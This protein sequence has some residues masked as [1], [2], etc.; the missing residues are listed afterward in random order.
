MTESL[1]D[2]IFGR[3]RN[4]LVNSP[5]QH[6]LSILTTLLALLP[7]SVFFAIYYLITSEG[8]QRIVDASPSLE[9]LVRG[10]DR[11]ES[12]LILS[13]VLF[14]GLGVYL[15]AL[16]ET[17]RTAGLMHRLDGRMK[18]LQ[19]GHYAGQVHPRRD[20]NFSHLATSMNALS[21]TLLERTEDDLAFLDE[22]ALSLDSLAAGMGT[23][24]RGSE[25]LLALRG[26]VE[27]L[28]RLKRSHL[29]PTGAAVPEVVPEVSDVTIPPP[30]PTE[31]SASRPEA[32]K[33]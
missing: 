29:V 23:E 17:H 5:Y 2:K 11:T 7:P 3:R 9:N 27:A 30:P 22:A 21:R 31:A 25:R 8:S 13:A 26:R 16:L 33:A 14:Y 18:D 19:D 24:I 28:R 12:I 6:R 1:T 15:V 4:F 32:F 20:D 10:Q